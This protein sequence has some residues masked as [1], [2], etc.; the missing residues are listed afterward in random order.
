MA[1]KKITRE[2]IINAFLFCAFDKSA[3]ATS[4]AD[5]ADYLEIKK[6]SLYNHF[7][8]KEEMYSASLEYCRNFLEETKFLPDSLLNERTFT[9]YSLEEIFSSLIKNYIHIYEAE[10]LF[11]IYTF[12]HTEQYFNKTASEIAD[13]ERAKIEYS[14]SQIIL[15]YC[16][17]KKKELS[18]MDVDC[19][20]R[21]YTS[22]LMNQIDMYI[23]NKKE[24]VRQNP[25][26][27]VGSLFALPTDEEALNRIYSLSS[28]YIR[29]LERD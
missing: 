22:A 15:A 13:A 20:V 6:A 23:T 25:E 29:L 17:Q 7:D 14:V 21:W 18:P 3:G 12:I 5:I 26:C 10:P 27:G 11:Q 24:I 4:L 8:S 16:S 9:A 1:K 28:N 19:A 2:K